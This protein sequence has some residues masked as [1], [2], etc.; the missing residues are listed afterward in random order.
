[1]DFGCSWTVGKHTVTRNRPVASSQNGN[2]LSKNCLQKLLQT[3]ILRQFLAKKA[4][5]VSKQL[6]LSFETLQE[7][8]SN[9]KIDQLVASCVNYL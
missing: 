9:S 8:S 4:S 3:G 2:L 7:L 5:V 1:M 6:D